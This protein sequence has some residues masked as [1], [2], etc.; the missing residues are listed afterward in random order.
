MKRA[1]LLSIALAMLVAAPGWAEGDV[2]SRPTFTKDVLPILQ[3]RCQQCHRS[4]GAEVAGMVAPM[5]LTSYSEVRPWAKAI[6]K[7]VETGQMPPPKR[8]RPIES[9]VVEITGF[10]DQQL[11]AV[12]ASVTPDPGRVTARRLNRQEY[13]NT[14]RR[15]C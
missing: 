15:W 2:P 6:G 3:A 7:A 4:S 1:I 12:W 8:P 10:V 5:A 14:V 13:N 9:D 11:E